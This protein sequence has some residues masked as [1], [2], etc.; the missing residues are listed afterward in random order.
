VSRLSPS[1]DRRHSFLFS[2]RIL[3]LAISPNY[4]ENANIPARGS[5]PVSDIPIGVII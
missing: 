2:S 1:C 5:G 4:V 3:N